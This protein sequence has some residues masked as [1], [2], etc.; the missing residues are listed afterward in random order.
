MARHATRRLAALATVVLIFFSQPSSVAYAQDDAHFA[1]IGFVQTTA[2]AIEQMKYARSYVTRTEQSQAFFDAIYS[3]I[4]SVVMKNGARIETG[5]AS[6]ATNNVISIALAFESEELIINKLADEEFSARYTLDAPIIVFDV[7]KQ[8]IM[9]SYPLRLASTTSFSHFPS[10]DELTEFVRSLYIVAGGDSTNALVVREFLQAL[11]VLELKEAYG[12]SIQVTDVFFSESARAYMQSNEIDSNF[13]QQQIASTFASILS[14]DLNIPVLP[15]LKGDAIE[16]RIA[17]NFFESGVLDL[18]LPR[19]TFAVKLTLRGLGT[20]LL[21]E[22]SLTKSYSFGSGLTVQIVDAAFNQV[23][24]ERSYQLGIPKSFTKNMIVNE[25]YWHKESL[26]ALM[27]G[28]LSQYS[29]YD[30]SWAK[31]HVVDDVPDRELVTEAQAV[32][33][34]VLSKLR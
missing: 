14:T 6:L 23:I 22:S 29:D 24:S 16:R 21:Q 28:I 3:G 20:K 18:E 19:A 4:G 8:S 31:E 25:R 15:F 5:P 12:F 11:S 30:K 1:G 2:S 26:A 9:A 27:S 17:L 32:N 10:E 13:F 7:S 33:N 34:N